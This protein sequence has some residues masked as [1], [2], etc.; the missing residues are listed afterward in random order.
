ME[1]RRVGNTDDNAGELLF[2]DRS[3]MDEDDVDGAR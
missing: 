2:R 1:R 3:P